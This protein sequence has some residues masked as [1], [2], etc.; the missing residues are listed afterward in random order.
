MFSK[1]NLISTLVTTVWGALGGFLLWGL[2]ADPYFKDHQGTATGVMKEEPDMMV[3]VLG[4]LIAGFIFSTIYSKWAR[5]SHS[6]THGAQFGFWIGLL[7]GFGDRLIEYGVA[8]VLD[9]NG[10]IVNGIV[11]VVF[12]IIMGILASLVYGK[13]KSAK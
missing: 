7:I 3:V 13:T 12:F 2:I 11:Y 9:L 6:L 4:S 1:A 10:T 5:G 8:N